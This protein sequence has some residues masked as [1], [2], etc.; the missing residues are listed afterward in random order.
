MLVGARTCS[1][2]GL[3]RDEVIDHVDF[4]LAGVWGGQ[5]DWT[6]FSRWWVVHFPLWPPSGG[7]GRPCLVRD[8]STM[9]LCRFHW[10]MVRIT[11]ELTIKMQK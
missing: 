4:L 1:V 6:A 8:F 2:N 9:A 3:T 7:L 11:F 5:H 10:L